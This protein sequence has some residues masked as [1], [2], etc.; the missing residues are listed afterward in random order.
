MPRK[1]H[2]RRR[3]LR[4]RQTRRLRGGDYR[5]ATTT[6]EQGIPLPSKA[7]VSV[8]GQSGILS[9]EQYKDRRERML[10]GERF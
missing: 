3:R 1:T 2:R 10:L 5:I 6:T 8:A 9:L 4:R 7:G